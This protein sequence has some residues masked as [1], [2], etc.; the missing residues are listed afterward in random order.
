[1]CRVG[2]LEIDVVNAGGGQCFAESFGPWSFRGADPKKQHLH[3]LVERGRVGKRAAAGS[4]RI[5]GSTPAAAA[6]TEASQGGEPVEIVERGGDSCKEYMYTLH[7][8]EIRP[9]CGA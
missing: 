1:V 7:R 5:E 8:Q 4:L 3:F 2:R 6:P 9:C